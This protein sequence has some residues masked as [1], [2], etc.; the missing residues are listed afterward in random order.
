MRDFMHPAL[1]GSKLLALWTT[2][3]PSI[4]YSELRMLCRATDT[5]ST[6]SIR[7]RSTDITAMTRHSIR[8]KTHALGARKRALDRTKMRSFETGPA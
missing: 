5:Q 2:M 6:I 7:T 3:V 8:L 4:W 1:N